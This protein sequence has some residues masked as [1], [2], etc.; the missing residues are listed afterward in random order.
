MQASDRLKKLEEMKKRKEEM[1]AR[2]IQAANKHLGGSTSLINPSTRSIHNEFNQ[3]SASVI[4]AKRGPIIEVSNFVGVINIPAKQ[5]AY[6]YDRSIEVTK[7][8]IELMKELQEEEKMPL[9]NLRDEDKDYEDGEDNRKKEKTAKVLPEEEVNKIFNKNHFKKFIRKSSE[10]LDSELSDNDS[11]YED[12]I[13]RNDAGVGSEKDMVTSLFNMSDDSTKDYSITNMLFSRTN[14]D[15]LLA[16]Y[17]TRDEK[18]KYKSKILVWSL[19]N[20][21]KPIHEMHS[22]MNIIRACFNPR[23]ENIIYAATYNGN[24]LQFDSSPDSGP[25]FKNYNIA[26]K[27]EYHATPIFSIECI[28][29]KD[30]QYLISISID[31]RL[32]VWDTNYLLEPIV[33]KIVEQPKKESTKVKL[34]CIHVLSSMV[35]QPNTDDATICLVTYDALII[36]I[37]V[38]SFFLKPDEDEIAPIFISTSHTAPICSLATKSDPIRPFLDNLMLTGSFDFDIQ[39]WNIDQNDATLLRKYSLHND[40][41]VSVEW[42]PVHPAMFASCDCSGRFLVFDLITN[43]IYFTFEDIVEN[44]MTMKWSPDGSK[45]AFGTQKGEI[46]V[47]QMRKKYLKFDEEKLQQLKMEL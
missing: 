5:K 33:N 27:G 21:L 1:E 17:S 30:A 32:C 29:W 34:D 46:Q 4:A 39:L 15:Q 2:R 42:N 3:P 37:R 14:A 36:M 6:M 19:K 40:Y 28:T 11:L 44:A 26:E 9:Y 10:I 18:Q 45:L 38:E 22:E 13:A 43:S 12:M 23:D 41:V 35:H 8:Q 16:I 47:W 20:K 31:G 7:E 25:Q 24:I